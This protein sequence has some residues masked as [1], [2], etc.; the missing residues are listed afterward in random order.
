[1]IRTVVLP[2]SIDGIVTGCILAV[3]RIVGESAILM[4]TAGMGMRMAQFGGDSVGEF[5]S[6]FFG[7]AGSTL[8]V[9]LYNYAKERA[10]FSSAFAVAVVLLVIA[11]VNQRRRQAGR[12]ETQEK[13]TSRREYI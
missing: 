6:N 10:D 3:G 8:T 4:F 2:S 7:A 12:Q 9:A 11:L 13:L 1:M 5:F